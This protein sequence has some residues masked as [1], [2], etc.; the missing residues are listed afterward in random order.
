MNKQNKSLDILQVM[1]VIAAALLAILGII[2]MS[3]QADSVP[4]EKMMT[5]ESP[6]AQYYNLPDGN[7]YVQKIGQTL[8]LEEGIDLTL[9]EIII[10]DCWLSYSLI[11]SGDI[12]ENTTSIHSFSTL[13]NDDVPVF[14]SSTGMMTK[15]VRDIPSVMDFSQGRF[16]GEN[17][18]VDPHK[19][20]LEL[21]GMSI[22]QLINGML[23]EYTVEGAWKFE[24]E[25]D[26]K[27]LIG[28]TRHYP[29][30]KSIKL[31]SGTL[32]FTELAVSPA[33]QR[34]YA[35]Y[36]GSDEQS[37]GFVVM[38]TDDGSENWLMLSGYTRSGEEPMTLFYENVIAMDAAD[39]NYSGNFFEA[40]QH[41]EK[42]ELIP[43][44]GS[45]NVMFDQR[46]QSTT[47]ME[48]EKIVIDLLK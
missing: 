30:D 21:A 28:D 35:K 25:A 16:E 8:T 31:A 13:I 10:G 36:E 3:V 12:A 22:Y 23:Q 40:I 1:L 46:E 17:R 24:F 14:T 15:L 44:L 29:L 2:G 26:A 48:E 32:S 9:D 7:P 6:L 5:A 19:F 34:L 38:R 33:D 20:V 45:N 27:T 37:V 39:G 42:L 4:L 18:F 11:L 43:R 41:S 47:A